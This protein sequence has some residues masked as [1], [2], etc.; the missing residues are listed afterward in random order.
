LG[1][2]A[3][4]ERFVRSWHLASFRCDTEFGPLSD[5]E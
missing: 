4:R 5:I 1:Y 2:Q 3:S